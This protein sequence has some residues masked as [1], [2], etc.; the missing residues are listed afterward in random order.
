MTYGDQRRSANAAFFQNFANDPKMTE[1]Q[2]REAIR[3]HYKSQKPAD[4]VFRQQQKNEN[5]TETEN[6]R[7]EVPS[8][9][10]TV[11]S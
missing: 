7:S 10:D 2:K 5:K 4:Q 3:A 1:E 8:S 11:T 9:A 6:I